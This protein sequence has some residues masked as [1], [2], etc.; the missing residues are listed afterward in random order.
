MDPSK[1]ATAAQAGLLV[2][3]GSIIY[4]ECFPPY[5]LAIERDADFFLYQLFYLYII[6]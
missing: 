3:A 6:V 4:Q 2:S 1:G 5:E